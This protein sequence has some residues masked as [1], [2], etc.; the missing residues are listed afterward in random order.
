V[1]FPAEQRSRDN[2]YGTQELRKGK[3]QKGRWYISR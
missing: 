2:E 3:K 1:I